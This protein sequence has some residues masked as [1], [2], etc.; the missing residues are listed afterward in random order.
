MMSD[1]QKVILFE[2]EELCLDLKT[3]IHTNVSLKIPPKG[4]IVYV[5]DNE[6]PT[7]PTIAYSNGNLIKYELE[8][9]YCS[10]DNTFQYYKNWEKLS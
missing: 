4:T 10:L 5:W 1:S 3:D 9:Y 2:T 8:V 6:R 7:E